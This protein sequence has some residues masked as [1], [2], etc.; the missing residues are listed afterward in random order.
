MRDST[1]SALYGGAVK[2]SPGRAR[3]SVSSAVINFVVLAIARR[4]SGFSAYITSPSRPSTT[5]AAAALRSG[6]SAESCA[7][8]DAGPASAAA[9]TAASVRRL[10]LTRVA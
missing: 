3:S 1:G 7:A 9:A 8:A 2:T 6:G 10:L 4:L 5:I